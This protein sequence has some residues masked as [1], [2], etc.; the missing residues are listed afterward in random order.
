MAF[1]TYF[2]AHWLIAIAC[3]LGV[4]AFGA[5][6]WFLKNWKFA[7]AAIVLAIFGF[8][9]QSA[10]TDGIKIQMAKDA[11]QR[12]EMLQSQIHKLNSANEADAQR[13]IED[14][15]TI[16]QLQEQVNATP[17]NDASCLDADSARRLHNIR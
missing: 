3:I 17:K 4:V 9:Y 8:L 14:Q 10:V 15:K 12:I 13:A 5:V 11:Q 7:V 2:G 6:A 1:L 16:E